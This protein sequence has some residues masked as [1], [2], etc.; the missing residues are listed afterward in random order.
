MGIS[1]DVRNMIIMGTGFCLCFTGYYTLQSYQTSVNKLIGTLSLAIAY[2]AFCLGSFISPLM[3]RWVPEKYLFLFG[4]LAHALF[5][6]VN[7]HVIT[8]LQLSFAVLVGLGGSCIWTAQGTFIQKM[9]E[10]DVLGR[11]TGIFWG[12]YISSMVFGNL[13]ASVI[14]L[15]WNTTVLFILLGIISTS[16]C[17]LFLALSETPVSPKQTVP[18]KDIFGFFLEPKM[19]LFIPITLYSSFMLPL[20]Y[21]KYSLLPSQQSIGF[22]FAVYGA[23]DAISCFGFGWLSDPKRW[24]RIPIILIG[25][26]LNLFGIVVCDY[27]ASGGGNISLLYLGFI[28]LGAG[29]GAMQTQISACLTRLQPIKTAA[30]FS[31]RT[32]NYASLMALIYVLVEMIPL[33]VLELMTIGMLTIGVI[34]ILLINRFISMNSVIEEQK[35]E[36][37]VEQIPI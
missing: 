29:D 16:G 17:L 25:Y 4:C 2:G 33:M 18:I 14:L 8:G 37:T 19:L 15:F 1:K 10:T 6:F 32:I 24:G 34:G 7:I 9:S 27:I 13:L 22:Y 26:I 28:F 12:L 20:T 36:I 35:I 11:N 21:S 23:A 31:W 3:L 5:I 30:V